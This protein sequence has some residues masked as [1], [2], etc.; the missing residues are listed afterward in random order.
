MKLKSNKSCVQDHTVESSKTTAE[1]QG[2]QST[3][4]LWIFL[5]WL[6]PGTWS[7]GAPCRQTCGYSPAHKPMQVSLVPRMQDRQ[8][9]EGAQNR[10]R[11]ACPCH[12]GKGQK[13]CRCIKCWV[14]EN[15]ERMTWNL[16]YPSHL[17]LLWILTISP[18][19][20][21]KGT[22]SGRCHWYPTLEPLSS[23]VCG[24]VFKRSKTCHSKHMQV[25]SG[26]R[27]RASLQQGPSCLEC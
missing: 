7:P 23:P 14:W 18:P 21:C 24:T 19:L 10:E 3:K 20:L 27:F 8:D 16:E 13:T 25:H 22:V 1:P 4:P 5:A 6:G 26:F 2:C 15:A 12:L 17:E 11:Q 9:A